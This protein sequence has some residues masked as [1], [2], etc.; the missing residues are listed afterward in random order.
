MSHISKTVT[1]EPLPWQK[2]YQLG[3]EIKAD[4]RADGVFRAD[5]HVQAYYER[6]QS[7][8][9]AYCKRTQGVLQA[10]SEHGRAYCERTVLHP[11]E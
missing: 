3:Y 6:T 10:D 7:M 1:L 4:A 9:K 5:E 2:G 8:H 11:L